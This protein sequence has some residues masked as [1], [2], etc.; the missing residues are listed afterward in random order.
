MSSS[1][2]VPRPTAGLIRQR[3]PQTDWRRDLWVPG[4]F[5]YDV[6]EDAFKGDALNVQYPGSKTN[7]AG[8]AVTFTEHS[9]GGFLLMD[10]G[11]ADDGYAGQGK[12]LQYNGDIGILFE[13]IVEIP[14]T[15]GS[16]KFEVGLSDADDIAGA[17]LDKAAVTNTATDYAVFVYDSDDNTSLAFQSGKGGTDVQTDGAENRAIAI[18]TKFLVAI[19]VVGDNVEAYWGIGGAIRRVAIHG[20]NAGIE[21]G[22]DLTPWFFCQNR[23]G[24]QHTMRVHKWRVTQPAY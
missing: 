22:T 20:G 23:D 1:V 24:N 16:I 18:D 4:S 13:A 5:D 19:R 2:I 11:S 8:A 6:D 21:G 12:G 3:I 9:T 15:L 7:G 10:A 17:V 14:T